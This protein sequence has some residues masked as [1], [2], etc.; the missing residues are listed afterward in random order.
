M[1]RGH[2]QRRVAQEQAREQLDKQFESG[3]F[4]INMLESNNQVVVVR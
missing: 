3:Q 2:L 4:E 1:T